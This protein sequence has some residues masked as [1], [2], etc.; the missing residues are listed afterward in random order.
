[1]TTYF[2][3]GATG[4]IGRRLVERLLSRTETDTVYALVRPVSKDKLTTLFRT[5]PG[6]ERLVPVTGELTEPELGVSAAELGPIDH[7]LHLAA[8][9]D[10]AA[11]E[12]TN[13][14][15]NVTGTQHVVDFAR[16]VQAG[17]LH[18]ISSIAVAGEHAGRFTERDFDVEQRFT[19]PYHATKFEAERLVRGLTD[20]PFTVYRP[21]AVVGDSRTGEMDKVDGPYYFLPAISRLAAAPTG[22]RLPGIELGATNLVPVDYV[23]DAVEYLMHHDSP[24][25]S[26]YHLGSPRP[27][28]LTEV[29]N[30]FAV[31]AG[32][33]TLG[34]S[35]PARPTNA[36]LGLGKG[37]SRVAG[38]L[39]DRVP[40]GR[41]ALA[42]VFEELGVPLEVLP[43]MTMRVEFDTTETN[44]AL[45]GS[46]IE[47]PELAE[48]AQPLYDYWCTHLDPDRART[49][50][51]AGKLHGRTVLITGSSS[52]IGRAAALKA[53]QR[54]AT[55]LL[56]ARRAGE[57]EEVRSEISTAGGTAVAYPCDLTDADAVDA[58]VKDVLAEHGAVDMLVNNAGRSI[59]RAVELSTERFHDYE[60]TMAINYF[61]AIRLI[62][63]LLP[64]MTQRRFGHIVNVTTQGLQT[65]TPRFSAYLAS[66]AALEE[67]G[68]AAGRETYGDGVTFSSVRMP[69][70]RSDMVTATGAYRAVPA[71]S[72]DTGADL[73]IKALEERPEVVN[74]PEGVAAELA[75]RVAP[76]LARSTAHMLYQFMPESA[77]EAQ[78]VPQRPTLA[79]L[80]GTL[81]R[82]AWRRT[83]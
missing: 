35:L 73:V 65:D 27:Q 79:R 49:P 61:A 21:S 23:V 48:Y 64:S 42:A 60:R 72:V 38:Q 83:P 62:L 16:R 25:G 19:S 30:A 5:V 45:V 8:S 80:T 82:L 17:R 78:G 70:V 44:A 28:P 18:H 20:V 56:V 26:T 15:L 69:L 59:R 24:S 10:L 40:T 46:G 57:L 4:F 53:A 81:T 39:V 50:S 43:H 2:V 76:K 51:D 66:K 33:P 29:Y 6:S 63:G 52:G 9:Y 32:A 12:Q 1:M 3:T 36:V 11:D 75:T 58:L 41:A 68:L 71:A 22:V 47:L 54:G 14:D 74:R 34:T 13:H 67:F 7:L 55:V 37:I 77:P 31:A